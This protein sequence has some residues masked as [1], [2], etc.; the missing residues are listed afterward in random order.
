MPF[1]VELRAGSDGGPAES[2]VDDGPRPA[3]GRD[4]AGDDRRWV[5]EETEELVLPVLDPD[6]DAAQTLIGFP[7]MVA[8][9]ERTLS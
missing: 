3:L 1:G 7:A 8:R 2:R 9:T 4:W 5:F 6:L